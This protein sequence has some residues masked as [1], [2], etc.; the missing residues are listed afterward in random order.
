MTQGPRYRVKPR[1]RR[2]GRT[3][4][5]KRLSLLRSNKT[6]MVVRKTNNQT[7]V[8]FVEYKEK[9]DHIIAQ[10][11]SKELKTNFNWKFSTSNTPAAYL[12]G[13]L[14]GMRAKEKKIDECILD[15]GRQRPVSGSKLFASLKGVIDTGIDCPHDE[16][17]IPNDDR[18]KGKHIDEKI[19]SQVETILKK[20]SGGK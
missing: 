7:I 9:G 13:Y 19:G 14:A 20:I 2:E 12:T 3:D 4:Y 11:I 17:K 1:R 10:A 15:I 16:K 6:R 8:Q 18:L 5:R